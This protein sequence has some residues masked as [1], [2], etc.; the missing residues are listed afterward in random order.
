[1]AKLTKKEVTEMVAF[2]TLLIHNNQI[3]TV[4]DDEDVNKMMILFKETYDDNE[5]K[6]ID[7][8]KDRVR[9][10]LNKMYDGVKQNV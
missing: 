10:L 1:M 9:K 7:Y 5:A 6:A 2:V 8:L 4:M 3:D